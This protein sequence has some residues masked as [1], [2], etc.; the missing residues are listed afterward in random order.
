MKI[1]ILLLLLSPQLLAQELAKF[2]LKIE[3]DQINDLFSKDGLRENTIKGCVRKI[4]NN[5]IALWDF[6][7]PEG[8]PRISKVGRKF[9]LLE[10]NGPIQHIF[11][12]ELNKNVAK[13]RDGQYFYIPR[14]SLGEL[15]IYGKRAQVTVL[16]WIK[17]QSDKNWQAIAGVWD[18]SRNKRQYFLFCNASLKTNQDEM[19]RYPAKNLV[20]GHIS[21][22]GGKS[23][24]EV[25]W[26]S[27]ASSNNEVKTNEWAMI[28][29]TYDG[30]KIKVYINGKLNFNEKTNPFLYT[31]G[32]FDG[33][34]NGAD[35]TV[36]ANSVGGKMTN[37]FIGL[38]DGLA[39]YNIAL[40][41]RE[42]QNIFNDTASQFK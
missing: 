17:K 14:D 31:E 16:A 18:E 39:V 11:D 33:G 38:I 36:G 6:A 41:E 20:H 26:I 37:Q 24:G 42:L 8:Q 3:D 2:N 15:N 29:M 9:C 10:G 7:E 12:E 27:Y 28:A 25:A 34:Q 22:T 40:S 23:P 30:E 21:A 5:L 4:N 13:I 35:F 19:V 32:I 1:L